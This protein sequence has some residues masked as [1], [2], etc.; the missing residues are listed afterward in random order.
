MVMKKLRRLLLL[1]LALSL[2]SIII[3]GMASAEKKLVVDEANLFTAAEISRLE[4]DVRAIGAKYQMDIVIVSTADAQKKSSREYS[5]DFFDSKGYGLGEERDGI[6]FLLDMDN[7]EVYISTSGKAVL[8]LTDQR[9]EGIL[10]DVFVGG[11]TDGEMYS[12]A[13]TFIVS[14]AECLKAGIPANQHSVTETKE[15]SLT[16]AEG[17]A[18]GLASGISGLGFYLLVKIRYRK[19]TSPHSFEYRKNSLVNL[20]TQNDHLLNSYVRSRVIPQVKKSPGSGGQTTVHR[21]SSGRMHG[22][23]GRKF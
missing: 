20:T 19:K 21:S 10:D 6:L 1:F 9:I 16:A 17:I 22:G 7:R 2:I 8:Y 18:G 3:A 11:L 15:N 4:E 23:G 12:A 5:D 14:V 13:S